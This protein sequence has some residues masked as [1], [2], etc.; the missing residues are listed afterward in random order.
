MAIRIGTMEDM[1]KTKPTDLTNNGQCSNCGSCC[2]N[3]LPMSDSEVKR[4]QSYIRKHGITQNVHCAL[5]AD[6]Q[7]DMLC[8]F[9]DLSKEKKCT[10]YP[11]RPQICRSFVCNRTAW[12]AAMDPELNQEERR[13][14]NVRATFYGG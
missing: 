9:M 2:S 7:Q 12:D 14:R 10:I 13:T 5:L 8:P 4:I 1:L 6:P 11:V 3:I